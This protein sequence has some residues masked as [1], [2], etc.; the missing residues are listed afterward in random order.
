MGGAQSQS[1]SPCIRARV[2]GDQPPGTS[3]PGNHQAQQPDAAHADD[4]HVVAQ[5]HLAVLDHALP[6]PRQRF[7]E[8]RRVKG[9]VGWLVKDT[10][11]ELSLVRIDVIPAR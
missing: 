9:Q 6:R 4:H 11:G 1:A 5:F 8:A 7:R 10:A 3:S 2:D